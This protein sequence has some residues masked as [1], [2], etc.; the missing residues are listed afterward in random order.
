MVTS[1]KDMLGGAFDA[2]DTS[3]VV[4]KVLDTDEVV[5]VVGDPKDPEY[6]G[7]KRFITRTVKI[8]TFNTKRETIEV[9]PAVC[10]KCGF[11]VVRRNAKQ[12]GT[13]E[14]DSLNLADKSRA[15]MALTAHMSR[16]GDSE[17]DLS[18]SEGEYKK[19]SSWS[20]KPL[21]IG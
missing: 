8:D 7:G 12:F 5:K 9:T 11:D 15:T 6:T 1:I 20:R 19:R 10:L 18:I 3:P 16:H 2:P 14:F 17:P 4:P 21:D 13:S